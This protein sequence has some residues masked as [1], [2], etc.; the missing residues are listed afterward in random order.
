MY[1]CLPF[2]GCCKLWCFPH[3]RQNLYGKFRIEK[4][5]ASATA[6]A[7]WSW[8]LVDIQHLRQV[9]KGQRASMCISN[10]G[11]FCVHN[12][13]IFAGR[14]RGFAT[15]NAIICYNYPVTS[16][17][18]RGTTVLPPRIGLPTIPSADKSRLKRLCRPGLRNLRIHASCLRRFVTVWGK[19][20]ITY[21]A[22]TILWK[23][24]R[25]WEVFRAIWIIQY[26]HSGYV[27]W[28]ELGSKAPSSS[29]L[30]EGS[31]G[32]PLW[33]HGWDGRFSRCC[34][35]CLEF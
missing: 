31:P 24:M 26:Q 10:W 18:S 21:Q 28:N 12:F 35:V 11:S 16:P 22:W 9:L 29:V 13:G 4:Q 7:V 25:I 34:P 14:V 27:T 17:V 30:S 32:Y 23:N 33:E 6:A 15:T 19:P 20:F 3:Q 2:R 8:V 1:T 5:T